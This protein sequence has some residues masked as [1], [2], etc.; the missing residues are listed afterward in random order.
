MWMLSTTYHQ[1]PR[2]FFSIIREWL[3]NPESDFTRTYYHFWIFK[4][5]IAI[6]V[7]ESLGNINRLGII[8]NKNP[9]HTAIDLDR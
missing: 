6:A 4:N 9:S 7:L 1:Y 2:A 8:M 3:I 5:A